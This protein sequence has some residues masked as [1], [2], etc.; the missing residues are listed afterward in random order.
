VLTID[1]KKAGGNFTSSDANYDFVKCSISGE[2]G[3]KLLGT[4]EYSIS[5]GKFLSTQNVQFMD[6]NHF[7]G[8]QTIFSSFQLNSFQ[9]LPYYRFSNTNPFV[10]FHFE[11]NFQGFIFNKFPLLRKLKLDEI[12]GVNYLTTD[13]L[14]QYYEIFAGISKLDL[15][16]LEVVGSYTKELGYMRGIRVGISL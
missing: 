1:Y 16:R 8:N 9:L 6:Y 15:V 11:H 14:P 12:A 3:L 5:A 7:D 2:L 4:S 10:E 13:N